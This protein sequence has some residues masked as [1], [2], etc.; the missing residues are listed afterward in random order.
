MPG[1]SSVG[2]ELSAN[3]ASPDAR[4]VALHF[5]PCT[6][7]SCLPSHD[8]VFV[9]SDEN[10]FAVN[11]RRRNPSRRAF[12]QSGARRPIVGICSFLGR[13]DTREAEQCVDLAQP[14]QKQN[15]GNLVFETP[16]AQRLSCSENAASRSAGWDRS[17]HP[18]PGPLMSASVTPV[19][20]VPVLIDWMTSQ[21]A[22]GE[23]LSM[24]ARAPVF[25]SVLTVTA[26]SASDSRSAK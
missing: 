24:P 20:A 18:T 11:L 6:D 4:R 26:T 16:W 2:I 5:A 19:V 15:A 22:L 13:F 12:A 14:F 7:G 8:R 10:A 25:F 21:I 3:F 1:Y 17:I 23:C 9:E